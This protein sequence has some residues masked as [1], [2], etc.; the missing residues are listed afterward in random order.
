MNSHRLPAAVCLLLSLTASATVRFVDL[1]NPGPAAPF[2]SWATAATNIQEAVDAAV[3]GDDIVVADGVYATGGRAVFGTMTNR[4][5]VDK[6]IN[7]RSVSGPSVTSIQGYQGPSHANGSSAIRCVYLTNG[8]FLSGFTLASGATHSAGDYDQERSG[9]GLWCESTSAYVSNCVMFDN[10]AG[11]GAGAY[12]GTLQ[13][14]TLRGNQAEYAGGGARFCTLESCLVSTNTAGN[15]GGGVADCTLNNCTVAG[16]TSNSGGGGGVMGSTLNNCIVYWNFATTNAD[17]NYFSSSF[18][19]SCTAPQPAGGAGNIAQ[20][21][22]FLGLAGW[23]L[24]LQSKSPCINAG[25]NTY[26]HTSR[27]LDGKPRIIGATVDMGAYEYQGI[28][29]PTGP[30]IVSQPA[31]QSVMIGSNATFTVSA[32]GTPPLAYW[33]RFNGTNLNGPTTNVLSLANVQPANAGNYS[34]AI[35]NAVGFVISS[36]A[37][38]SVLPPATA[39]THYVDLTSASP[40]SPFTNWATAARTIQDAVDAAVPG[41][42][43][44]VTNG[45]YATGGR[46]VY[47]TSLN[48]VAVNKAVTIRSAQGPQFTFIEGHQVPGT[49]NG[50]AAVRC[51]YLANGANLIGFTLTNGATRNAGDWA[52]QCGGALWCGAT[53][54][55]SVAV[56]ISNCVITGNAAAY[57]GGGAYQGTFYNCNFSG[58]TASWGGGAGWAT[59]FDC[60]LTN[61]SAGYGGG[62]AYSTLSNCTQSANSA[63]TAGGGG[64]YGTLYR[65]RLSGNSAA[66]G[67][68][69]FFGTLHYCTLTG[70]EASSL[71]GGGTAS[72]SLNNCV[73]V[74][75]NAPTGGGA[76]YGSLSNCTLYANSATSSGGGASISSLANCIVISN[77]APSGAN[78]SGGSLAWCCTTPLPTDGQ[79]NLATDPRVSDAPVGNLRLQSNSP[80]INAGNNSASGGATDF[81]GNPRISSG[82][83]DIGA[84]EYQGNLAPVITSQPT[85]Q[86]VL[87]GTTVTFSVTVWGTPPFSYQWS[88]SGSP[89]AGATNASL[90]LTNAQPGQ[91]GN[92]AVT[93]ANILSTVTSSNALLQ[94]LVSS[95]HYVDAASANP[96]S[97]FTSWATA[98]TTIQQAVDV[99]MPTEEIV[100]TNGLYAAGGRTIYGS[101]TNRVAVTKAVIVRSVNG[102]AA[103]LIH[104]YQVP[105]TTNGDAAVRCVY[106]TNGAALIGFTLTNGATRTSGDQWR[107]WCGGGLW[108]ESANVVV[109]NCVLAGNCAYDDGGGAY[110]GTLTNCTLVGNT[111]SAGGGASGRWPNVCN[112]NGCMVAGNRASEGGG[113]Y[114]CT[115]NNCKFIGN[116]AL[117]LGGGISGATAI[118]CLVVSNS[119]A[120]GGGSANSRLYNC[121][122]AANSAAHGGGA[123]GLMTN[124]VLY[125]SIVYYNTAPD[126]SNYWSSQFSYCCTAPP[127]QYGYA[128]LTNEPQFL[129]L[130]SGNLRLRATSPCINAGY[131]SYTY[132]STADLDGNPRIVGGTVDIGA[133]EFG[134][135][136]PT[137]KIALSGG[138]IK[139]AW[140]LWASDF[141]LQAGGAVGFP[142]GWSNVWV[143]PT[144]TNDE[145]SVTLPPTGET[146]YYRLFKP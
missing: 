84:Y 80:C 110:G 131:N 1:N 78:Y 47:G 19:Y 5:V 37:L 122:V 114:G 48:R 121:T 70:N 43:I 94:V 29:A 143:Y 3:A 129:N 141:S 46:A 55:V 11:S 127:P 62:Q 89:L 146:R 144:A 26:A 92:Y 140:P 79:G 8:A 76:Y 27:D 102:P 93:V 4:V 77:T 10:L 111:A 133:Y 33:W 136:P 15:N 44:V 61:N 124:S 20:D 95:I 100:V 40:T 88:L 85:N 45:V 107:E 132:G 120:Y 2:T 128:N 64:A 135:T 104:G 112:L 109:S 22:L 71:Y 17:R 57:R 50:D 59:L 35:S 126:G 101:L 116:Y 31:E 24:H 97:P 123:Y 7:V 99:A 36:N 139:L 25:N 14:C 30:Y 12:S 58:N 18:N 51:V 91:S 73:L 98:A 49:T 67:G 83:V 106:L 87:A 118:N 75:N 68:G 42:N 96:V 63:A 41:D 115:L 34:V 13:N 105:G 21:P 138:D 130:A 81:D 53:G 134:S 69:Q 66:Q 28:V 60:G 82:I 65:C 86:T 52:E 56:T 23:D 32:G 39:A 54:I 72:G 9:G 38:L 125:N 137:I 90:V 6:A 117:N 113:V 74:G 16:N 103:T 119:S 142:G 145:N 108:C